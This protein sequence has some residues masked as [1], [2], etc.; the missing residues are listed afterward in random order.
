MRSDPS[1]RAYILVNED[2]EK[3]AATFFGAHVSDVATQLVVFQDDSQLLEHVQ[4]NA[5]RLVWADQSVRLPKQRRPYEVVWS[6]CNGNQSECAMQPQTL[7]DFEVQA[8]L[9]VPGHEE[10]RPGRDERPA[11]MLHDARS[12]VRALSVRSKWTRLQWVAMPRL[13]TSETRQPQLLRGEWALEDACIAYRPNEMQGPHR[14]VTDRFAMLIQAHVA[15]QQLLWPQPWPDIFTEYAPG[16]TRLDMGANPGHTLPAWTTTKWMNR[17]MPRPDQCDWHNS[18]TA[19]LTQLTMDNLYHAFIHAVPTREYHAKLMPHLRGKPL[20]ILPHWMFYWPPEGIPYIGWQMIARS[21]GVR[22]DEWPFTEKLANKQHAARACRCYRRIYGGHSSYMPP[23][24]TPVGESRTRVAA[25]RQGISGSLG[26]PILPQPQ[27]LFQLRRGS[28]QIVNEAELRAAIEADAIVGKSVRFAVMEHLRV[29]DQ[30]ELVQSSMA[31]AGV[32]GMGLAW[33][34]LLNSTAGGTRTC[35]EILGQWPS[36]NRLD[37]YMLSQANGVYYLRLQQRSSPE[38]VCK[39]CHYRA[40][41]NVTANATE[42]LPVLQLMVK[43]WEDPVSHLGDVDRRKPPQR[44]HA[45][46]TDT[47]RSCPDYM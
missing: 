31:L 23:P 19:F 42:I 16:Y 44:C 9:R 4:A 27:I 5:S 46:V 10:L 12:C 47:G 8:H 35:L 13:A 30:Y 28:R 15:H 7:V 1:E 40:C 3:A 45:V 20:H 37:Y 21:L 6:W 18:T 39:G 33:T 43:R 22:D 14:P 24:H 29:M 11:S 25:F 32:H 41:G 26:R 34:M 2:G 36:F 38:C 17:E